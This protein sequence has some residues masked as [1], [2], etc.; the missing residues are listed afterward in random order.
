MIIEV[1]GS[2][3]K[4]AFAHDIDKFLLRG[5]ASRPVGRFNRLGQDALYLSQNMESARSALSRY[6]RDD[7]LPRVAIQYQI[8]PCSVFDLRHPN[9]TELLTSSRGS[10]EEALEKKTT[11]LSWEVADKI[12][13]FGCAGLIDPSRQNSKVWHLVL[14]KWNEA[15]APMVERIG[16]L[17]SVPME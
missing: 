13:E 1:S 4:I 6:V 11:P 16:E 17:V 5:V 9:A 12:R 14:F 3:T 2:F 7:D 10:W 8:E 15:H